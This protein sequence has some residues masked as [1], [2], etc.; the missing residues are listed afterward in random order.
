MSAIYGLIRFDGAPIDP[1]HLH[2]M[3]AAI[4]Y[5]GPDGGDLWHEGGAA[6]GQLVLHNTA[7]SVHECGPSG[8]GSGAMLVAAARLDN[9]DELRDVLRVPWNAADTQVIAAAY[10]RWGE[11]TPRRLSGDWSF[12]AWHPAERRLFLARDHYGNT[13]LYYHRD[14]RSFSF[15]SSRKALFALPDVP[16]RLNELRLA[17]HLVTWVTDG[18]ATF[19]E[20]IFRLPPGH[21]LRATPDGLTVERYWRLEDAPEVRLSSDEEYVEQFLELYTAAVRSRLRTTRGIASTL[22]AGLD[23]SSVTALAARELLPRGSHLTALTAIPAFPEIAKSLPRVMVDEWEVAHTVAQRYSNVD[24][25][26]VRAEAITPLQ[27]F[28]RSLWLH[29]EPEYTAANLH[30]IT[31]LLETSRDVAAGVLLTGQSGNG[32]VSWSGDLLG[33]S[34]LFASGHWIRGAAALGKWKRSRN[35]SWTGAVLLHLILPIRTLARGWAFRHGWSS[36]IALGRD[37]INPHF[38]RR[39]NLVRQMRSEGYD[40]TFSRI[41]DPRSQRLNVVMPA[42]TSV[43]ALWSEKGAGYGLEVRDPTADARLLEFCLGVPEEQF[44]RGEHDRWLMRRA[45]EDVLPPEVQWSSR[46][47]RQSADIALRLLADRANVDTAVEEVARSAAAD[48]LDVASLRRRWAEIQATPDG[49]TLQEAVVF[50]R[51]LLLG[52]F[53]T[54]MS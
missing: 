41:R 49:R 14:A 32:G 7:E 46:R 21:F 24:H 29:D 5:W 23:S 18:A 11:D 27:A 35:A 31:G 30:W 20:G 38:E 2:S 40:P 8:V 48:Y 13:S 26:A 52:R 10:E 42:I 50:S 54:R 51:T 47:G 28:D 53:V 34:R 39:L 22:S 43:G 19:H 9:R 44:V 1:G 16:R 45:M 25:R 4:R 12:V 17:Q 36:R 37:V 33:T 3:A 6:L 15:A